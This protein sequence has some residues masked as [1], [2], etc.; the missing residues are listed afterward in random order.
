MTLESRVLSLGG[1][2]WSDACAS[3]PSCPALNTHTPSTTQSSPP[4]L[5]H[6]PNILTHAPAGERGH[7]TIPAPAPSSA[8]EPA[9]SQNPRVRPPALLKIP[10]STTHT[11]LDTLLP[12]YW[13]LR[14]RKSQFIGH[15]RTS[16]SR[17]RPWHRRPLRV[18]LSR[19]IAVS[20]SNHLRTP[21]HTC[22]S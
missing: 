7:P 4:P 22:C 8:P 1:E 18:A 19:R 21:S 15:T 13:R 9:R 14:V 20:S 5:L 17:P 2:S 11:H 12:A 16:T 6:S 10:A 3:A